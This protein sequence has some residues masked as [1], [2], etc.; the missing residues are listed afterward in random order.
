MRI[1]IG[2]TPL[3]RP[4]TAAS[5][6][7]SDA[8]SEHANAVTVASASI[9]MILADQYGPDISR[10][11]EFIPTGLDEELLPPAARGARPRPFPYLVYGGEYHLGYGSDFL[12]AFA[13]ALK[14]PEVRARGPK[15]LVVGRLDVNAPRLKPLIHRLEL[16]DA[17]ELVDQVPQR[18]LYRLLQGA[19]AGVVVSAR[20]YQGWC[21]YAK[22]VDYLALRLPVVAVVPDPSEAR[23][24]LLRTGLG[25]FLD[26]GI[27]ACSKTLVH[28]LLGRGRKPEAIGAECDRFLAGVR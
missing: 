23:S 16:Q 2:C 9:G 22:L 21:L 17:V 14:N 11:V 1:A 24:H 27:D 28:F 10:R 5:G 3:I 7:W 18:E 26:G 20:H 4:F 12:E 15:L 13:E 25:V 8:P 6:S 19:E